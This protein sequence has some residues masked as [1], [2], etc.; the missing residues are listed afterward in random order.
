MS[1]PL[2]ISYTRFSSA[3]QSKGSSLERQLQLAEDYASERGWVIDKK[4]S[5]DDKALSGFT[6]ENLTRGN[7][8]EL[9]R[10][11]EDGTIPDGSV[12]LVE[13]LDRLS[14]L[15]AYDAF[16]LLQKILSCGIT[17]I[18]LTDN[19]E[20]SK[21]HLVNAPEKIYVLLGILIRANEESKLKSRRVLDAW[22]RKRK[23][24]NTVKLTGKC[25]AWLEL[26][27]DKKEF[28]TITERVDL[29]KRIFEMSYSGIGTKS[30]AK[31]LNLEN[32]PSWP[33]RIRKT[34][35]WQSSYIDK[36]LNNVAVI[37][38]FQPHSLIPESKIRKPEG[39]LI[40][41]YFPPIIADDI[42]YAVQDRIKSNTHK[43]GKT[44]KISNLFGG[45]A[46][47]GYCKAP[48]ELVNKGKSPKGG[49]YLVCNNARRG[50][51]CNYYSLRYKEI[52]TAFL[53]YFKE[54]DIS[55]VLELEN[56]IG[57]TNLTNINHQLSIQNGLL[58]S[59]NNSISLINNNILELK[60]D[61]QM[62]FF[63]ENVSILL[64]QKSEIE[65]S[66]ATLNSNRNNIIS[67][68]KNVDETVNTVL[69]SYSKSL[70]ESLDEKARI[71]FRLKLRSEIRQIVK[72]IVVYPRGRVYSEEQIEML[73]LNYDTLI[74]NSSE[75]YRDMFRQA[76]DEQA[77]NMRNSQMNTK[78]ERYFEIHF[79]NG[80]FRRINYSKK[81]DIFKV[82][83]DRVG[84]R[85]DWMMGDKQIKPV[86]WNDLEQQTIEEVEY[87]KKKHPDMSSGQAEEMKKYLID[88]Y[89]QDS[90]D[91]DDE[92]PHSE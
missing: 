50:L 62:K 5:C 9:L 1:N 4:L 76:R 84:N 51:T 48:M 89:S 57:K 42:F 70:D 22:Y 61:S 49:Q 72:H 3:I 78:D 74:S 81:D 64:D 32:I 63:M 83:F 18:T 69:L 56:T 26:T 17:I 43:G 35:G 27:K 28:V 91:T 53:E 10:L 71:L 60:T 86:F 23:N 39:E 2:Y 37:G 52:E 55:S 31:R 66:I 88:Q 24:I 13:S 33:T 40:E 6:G 38:K 36:I 30:I 44:G 25:P 75:I 11:M 41:N 82:S 79:K 65:N 90:S 67:S 19:A 15:D 8:G 73:I 34:S 47:C 92:T 68:L 20:Y 45:I 85:V 14:R 12:L 87:Y 54:I 58:M 77:E 21:Q 46:I 80:N 59:I 7:L 29:I 16:A